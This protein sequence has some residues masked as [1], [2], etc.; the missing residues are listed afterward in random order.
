MGVYRYS[1]NSSNQ[2]LRKKR[3]QARPIRLN[4]IKKS[5][6][7][8]FKLS[9]FYKEKTR[10]LAKFFTRRRT[11][12][13]I[14]HMTCFSNWIEITIIYSHFYLLIGHKNSPATNE[15]PQTIRTRIYI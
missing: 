3:K 1:R 11:K 15:N 7:S 2:P 13:F 6:F 4:W 9:E 12:D 14:M 10:K 8:S 5:I